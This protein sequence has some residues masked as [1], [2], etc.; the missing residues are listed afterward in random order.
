ML[1][2]TVNEAIA[3][4][5]DLM[6]PAGPARRQSLDDRMRQW[7]EEHPG[8]TLAWFDISRDYRNGGPPM[9]VGESVAVT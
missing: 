3:T 1:V 4:L 8:Q 7:I 2:G 9:A 6:L 5:D